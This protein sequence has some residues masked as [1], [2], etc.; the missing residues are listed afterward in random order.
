MNDHT[1]GPGCTLSHR[2]PPEPPCS[3]PIR[4]Y[5]PFQWQT[6]QRLD[7][8]IAV[9]ERDDANTSDR[10][11]L[12]PPQLRSACIQ[13]LL[14]ASQILTYLNKQPKF[15]TSVLQVN[16]LCGLTWCSDPGCPRPKSRRGQW[17]AASGALPG[18]LGRWASSLV[19]GQDSGPGTP[20][21]EDPASGLLRSAEG[22]S[23]ILELPAALGSWPSPDQSWPLSTRGRRPRA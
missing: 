13:S 8:W 19:H 10:S 20:V 23:R 2:V 5:S 1:R 3:K 11:T 7:S 16:R 6:E 17:G 18:A 4:I 14:P 15:L 9:P 12:P 22:H 21:T